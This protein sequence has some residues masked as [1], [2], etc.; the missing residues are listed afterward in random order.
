MGKLHLARPCDDSRAR[1]Q[2]GNLRKRQD[3]PV[4]FIEDARQPGGDDRL[5]LPQQGLGVVA[6]TGELQTFGDIVLVPGGLA[7][8]LSGGLRGRGFA[9]AGTCGKSRELP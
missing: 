4:E 5:E 6:E 8:P 1:E 2:P 7:L 3:M 9:G